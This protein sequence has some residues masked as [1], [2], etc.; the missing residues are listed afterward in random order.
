MSSSRLAPVNYSEHLFP[1][2]LRHFSQ[3]TNYMP[4]MRLSEIGTVSNLGTITICHNVK[5]SLPLIPTLNYNHSVRILMSCVFKFPWKLSSPPALYILPRY[6]F[7]W[8]F[9]LKLFHTDP[10]RATYKPILTS[11]CDN[12]NDISDTYICNWYITL[13]CV[14]SSTLLPSHISLS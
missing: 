6:I 11:S 10:M 14:A 3:N 2:V 9:L 7:L 4:N 1:L 13:D 12:P 5:N 8:V